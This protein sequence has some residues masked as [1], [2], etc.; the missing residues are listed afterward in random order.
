M[1]T[2]NQYL[3]ENDEKF[4]SV[5][6]VKALKIAAAEAPTEVMQFL[7]RIAKQFPKIQDILDQINAKN[8][9]NDLNSDKDNTNP[10]NEFQNKTNV[11]APNYADGVHGDLT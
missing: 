6:L 8:L 7:M 5:E 2:F 1:K 11:V 3:I 4:S 10:G 9:N